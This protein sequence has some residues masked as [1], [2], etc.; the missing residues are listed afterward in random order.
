VGQLAPKHF[1]VVR[2]ALKASKRSTVARELVLR[3]PLRL[4]QVQFTPRMLWLL[5]IVATDATIEQIDKRLVDG[6]E[7]LLQPGMGDM[8]D[9]LRIVGV[10]KTIPADSLRGR[11]SV[12]PPGGWA[13]D[14]KLGAIRP[15]LADN[16]LR[17]PDE[18]P[19]DM[20]QRAAEQI[21]RRISDAAK[22]LAAVAKADRWFEEP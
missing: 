15:K 16:I 5:R 12:L 2:E 19:A 10:N 4:R 8:R 6:P 3:E 18:W 9:L 14:V 11:R 7:T 20:V 17:T 13:S 22:P 1:V 21:A